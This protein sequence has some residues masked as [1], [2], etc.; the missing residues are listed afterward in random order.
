VPRIT[1]SRASANSEPE[2]SRAARRAITTISNPLGRSLRAFRNHSL[3]RRFTRLRITELPTRLLT[4][5]PNRI[6]DSS[7]LVA[8]PSVRGAITTTKFFEVPR[9]PDLTARP[10]S[11]E[12]RTRSARRKRPVLES[13]ALLRGNTSCELFPTFRATSFEYRASCTRLGSRAKSVG[14]FSSDTARLVGPFHQRFSIFVFSRMGGLGVDFRRA[15]GF[16][17]G[18]I[19]VALLRYSPL[20]GICLSRLCSKARLSKILRPERVAIAPSPCQPANL[21]AQTVRRDR[22]PH[23][24][25]AP[26]EAY[27]THPQ[28][29]FD[30]PRPNRTRTQT[31]L[32]QRIW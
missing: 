16:G 20:A 31:D 15:S 23:V 1:S 17:A 4:V 22:L 12:H 28:W 6:R 26:R 5:T 10:N 13:T 14:S 19:S 9:F 21:T 3:I 18:G 2:S 32:F 30:S 25:M 27:S 11:R 29:R 24:K 8:T 7:D